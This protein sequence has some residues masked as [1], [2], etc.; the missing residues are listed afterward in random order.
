[1]EEGT[2]GGEY[3]AAR[4]RDGASREVTLRRGAYALAAAGFV[5]V[6]SVHLANEFVFDDWS[7][8]LNPNVEGNALTWVNSLVTLAAA[9]AAAL[10][11]RAFGPRGRQVLML[12]AVVAFFALDDLLAIHES[13]GAGLTLFGLPEIGG[14]WVALYFPLFGFTITVLWKLA[15]DAAG[16]PLLRHG[17]VLLAAA[18]AAD[19]FAAG[20]VPAFG[21]D[22][23]GWLYELEIALEEA[24]ELAGWLLIACGLAGMWLAAKAATAPATDRGQ[25]PEP[26]PG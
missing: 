3:V 20:V 15:E 11:A 8:H 13:L 18:V 1:V 12:A 10:L 23:G 22:R 21:G 19:L 25:P 5:A 26:V 24:A 6:G 2:L 9:G 17:V 7:H 4:R 14:I 16:G